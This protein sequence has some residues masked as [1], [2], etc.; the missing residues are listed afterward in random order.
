[1]STGTSSSEAASSEAAS[2]TATKASA[3]PAEEA[4][5]KG[6]ACSSATA[7]AVEV[8]V[9]VDFLYK[10]AVGTFI[11]VVVGADAQTAVGG[12]VA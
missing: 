9:P 4:A 6:S 2:E 1:M 8:F 5:A 3:S 11:G 10:E 7:A 12:G